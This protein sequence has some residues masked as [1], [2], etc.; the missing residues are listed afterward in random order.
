MAISPCTLCISS[1]EE[2]PGA[3]RA[4]WRMLPP[5]TSKMCLLERF[6]KHNRWGWGVIGSDGRYSGET[7]ICSNSNLENS[8]WGIGGLHTMAWSASRPAL[9]YRST[10][11]L[12]EHGIEIRIH[13]RATTIVFGTR[14]SA[15]V[16]HAD[17]K[18]RLVDGWMVHFKLL[19]SFFTD[20]TALVLWNWKH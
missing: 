13:I 10:V 16:R 6:F 2:K 19:E 18:K 1:D 20:S 11:R 12:E 9:D 15:I 17:D 8:E 3:G 4:T 5:E 7:S 14:R